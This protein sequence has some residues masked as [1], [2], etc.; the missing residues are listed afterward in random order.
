MHFLLW[1]VSAKLSNERLHCKCIK[2]TF[3]RDVFICDCIT[4][5]ELINTPPTHRPTGHFISVSQTVDLS[6]GHC[7]P[8][9]LHSTAHSCF[10][11]SHV[12][13]HLAL[14]LHAIV[15]L[16]CFPVTASSISLFQFAT[17]SS[18]ATRSTR[19]CS[20]LF[21]TYTILSERILFHSSV[22]I[23]VSMHEGS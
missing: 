7:S 3:R 14:L 16:L 20:L 13:L 10:S 18:L 6:T 15:L 8:I 11:L 17:F 22:C 9:R 19:V 12:H 21:L 5:G 2:R 4:V 1:Y 23:Q